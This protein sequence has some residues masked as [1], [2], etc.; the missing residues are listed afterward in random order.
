VPATGGVGEPDEH[1]V[2]SLEESSK[3]G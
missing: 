2:A 3:G 1:S